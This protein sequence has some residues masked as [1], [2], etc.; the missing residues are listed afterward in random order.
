[1]A[2]LKKQLKWQELKRKGECLQC[3]S[4]LSECAIT[5]PIRQTQYFFFPW[6]EYLQITMDIKHSSF[7]LLKGTAA[8]Q[9]VVYSV[10]EGPFFHFGVIYCSK[11]KFFLSFVTHFLHLSVQSQYADIRTVF[12]FLLFPR[13]M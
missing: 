9:S 13:T 5:K 6:H 4:I 3:L 7:H 11:H 12:R 1:M 8:G 2:E 10:C